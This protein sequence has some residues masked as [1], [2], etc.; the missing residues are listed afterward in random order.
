MIFE[1]KVRTGAKDLEKGNSLGNRAILEYFENIASRHADSLGYGIN[2]MPLTHLSWLLLDWYVRVYHRPSYG[3]ELTVRTW[4]R[5]IK[6]AY[7]YR[8]FELLDSQGRVCA[9]AMSKWVLINTEKH[10]IVKADEE[11]V[12]K[13]AS[14]PQ[15]KALDGELSRLRAPQDFKPQSSYRVLRRDIDIFGHMHN[16]YYLDLA[17]ESLPQDA[18]ERR[19]FDEI[20]INY[21][22]ESRLG[23]TLALSCAQTDRGDWQVVVSSEDKSV[24]HSVIALGYACENMSRS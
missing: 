10:T 9:A 4:S 2:S 11:M 18:Y 24:I 8:D 13:Y 3:Q 16:L 6:R 17:Y 20:R 7:G 1:E 5:E 12:R 15:R 19:L 14:E 23:E 22:V 21:S